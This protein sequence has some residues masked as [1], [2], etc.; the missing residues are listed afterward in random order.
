[1][2][3]LRE[4][5]W[6]W[7]HYVLLRALLAAHDSLAWLHW[8]LCEPLSSALTGSLQAYC[9]STVTTAWKWIHE[10]LGL[11]YEHLL[12]NTYTD[13]VVWMPNIDY[14]PLGYQ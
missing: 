8:L 12:F 13:R 14:S 9:L 5:V 1:M 11:L 10:R 4:F 6:I 2:T 3:P 7:V